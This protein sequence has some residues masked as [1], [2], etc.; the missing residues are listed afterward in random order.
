MDTKEAY[1]RDSDGK[2][3]P[4]RL[5]MIDA[6]FA[7]RNHPSEWSYDPEKFAE[8]K[9]KKT[10]PVGEAGVVGLTGGDPT[11]ADHLGVLGPASV[12]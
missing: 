7:V 11:R 2:V 10:E 3:F 5:P 9:G 1:F 12:A 6:A 8:R 4:A